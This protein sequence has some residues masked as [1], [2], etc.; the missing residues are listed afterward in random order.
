MLFNSLHFIIFLPTVL[1]LYFAVKNKYRLIVILG[2][3]YY[4]Y[5]SW[6]VEYV[7]LL[8]ICTLVNYFSAIVINRSENINKRKILLIFSLIVSLS[9]LFTFKYF[10]FV[11]DSV[12]GFLKMFSIEF[13]PLELNVLLPIGI[14]FYTFQAIGYTID[15]YRKKIQPEKHF[16]IFALYVSFFP[17]LVAG[18]IERAKNLIPQF[19]EKHH[20]DY[21]RVTQGLK[22]MLW[23]FFKKLIIRFKSTDFL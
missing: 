8:L 19:F 7:V 12:N 4:F 23:G 6:R 16:G 5:M 14:S 21:E 17:Q 10:N 13:T 9:L 18:P 20:F 3:S 1:L 15:V 2:S 11:G 22:L